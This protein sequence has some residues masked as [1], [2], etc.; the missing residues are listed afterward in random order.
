MT[1]NNQAVDEAAI[2]S[3]IAKRAAAISA[4][5]VAGVLATEATNIV[6]AGLA[7]PLRFAGSASDTRQGMEAWF[8][9]WK[10]PIDYEVRDLNITAGDTVAFCTDFVRI[11][12]TKTDGEK[13]EIWAR[14]TI[15]LQKIGGAWKIVHDHHSVPFYM[16]GSYRAAVD[17]KPN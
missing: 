12:G 6:M 3:V 16:D 13:S 4:K 10:G 14:Q 9:T 15:G 2:R 17:L 8:A 11:G 7:P 5:D 1:S